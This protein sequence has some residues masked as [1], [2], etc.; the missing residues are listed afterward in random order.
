MNSTSPTSCYPPHASASLYPLAICSYGKTPAHH[1][2]FMRLDRKPP[3]L[4]GAL[5]RLRHAV[6]FIVGNSDR[7]LCSLLK[8]VLN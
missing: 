3:L 1:P 6:L 7:S 4:L 8:S 2:T 5:I